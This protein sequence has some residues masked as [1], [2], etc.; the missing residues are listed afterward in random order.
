MSSDTLECVDQFGRKHSV[1]KSQVTLRLSAAGVLIR[2]GRVLLV[3]G[4]DGL[5]ELPGGAM[6][7][8]ESVEEGL[9]REYSEETGVEVAVGQLLGYGEGFYYERGAAWHT[10]RLFFSVVPISTVTVRSHDSVAT[11]LMELS[12]LSPE[13]TSELTRAMIPDIKALSETRS[14]SE[15]EFRARGRTRTTPPD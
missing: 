8:D 2:E 13:L 12:S 7:V 1:P 9:E 15:L 6:A 5:W 10:V 14:K 4:D 3:R 11:A